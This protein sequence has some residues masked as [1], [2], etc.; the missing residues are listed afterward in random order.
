M[1]GHAGSASEEEVAELVGH[2]EHHEDGQHEHDIDE[3]VDHDVSRRNESG[4]EGRAIHRTLRSVTLVSVPVFRF[5]Q[6]CATTRYGQD[7]EK[8]PSSRLG[9]SPQRVLVVI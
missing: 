1:D 6:F 3:T 2:D 5:L 8:D 9:G 4:S 7:G